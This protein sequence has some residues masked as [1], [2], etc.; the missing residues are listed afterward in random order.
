[1]NGWERML[2]EQR[3]END[4]LRRRVDQ[5]ERALSG[6]FYRIT[7]AV[8]FMHLVMGD[9]PPPPDDPDSTGAKR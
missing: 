4:R 5:L 7:G 2:A 8:S 3:E 1:M 6:A 9:L